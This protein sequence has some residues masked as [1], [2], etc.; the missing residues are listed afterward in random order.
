VR[1][2]ALRYPIGDFRLSAAPA[3]PAAAPA[4]PPPPEPAMPPSLP[5]T[6][7]VDLMSPQGSPR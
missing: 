1:G 6:Y 2:A 5:P 3:P 4:G 7:V